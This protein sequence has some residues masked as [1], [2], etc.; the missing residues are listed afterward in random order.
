MGSLA[1]APEHVLSVVVW[2]ILFLTAYIKC[3]PTRETEDGRGTV[4]SDPA[5]KSRGGN[6]P[7]EVYG[8]NSQA[9]LDTGTEATIIGED[10]YY[11][12]NT[13]KQTRTHTKACFGDQQN[14]T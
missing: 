12:G 1:R 11:Q 5:R 6:W 10:L 9:L 2:F 8:I 14:A 4:G 7:C 3:V 13:R